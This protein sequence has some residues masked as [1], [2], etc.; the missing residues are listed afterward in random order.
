MPKE[1]YIEKKFHPKTEKIIIQ[2]NEIID[3]YAA[4]GLTLTLRQ[5]YYQFVARG[6]IANK[7]EEYGRLG[8]V[9]NN[10]RLAGLI[11]WN[12]IEDRTRNLKGLSHWENPGE[13][14]RAAA[15][16][17]QIDHWEGQKI[18]PEVWIEKEALVGIIVKVCE[19]LDVPYFAC[20]GYVSQSEMWR[21]SKRFERYR[22]KNRIPIII[23]LGDHDPSGIDMTRDINDRQELF[24]G[25]VT[26][27]RIALNMDQ[28]E[29]YSPPP[30]PAKISDSRFNDYANKFGDESWEFRCIRTKNAARINQ[31]YS[32]N[33]PR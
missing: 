2:V 1:T 22:D 27:K 18:Q 13:I 6:F 31:E 10:G 24:I 23:H 29:K 30:N 11:D 4:D 5:L 7:Q 9:V 32:F 12:A 16:G 14:I 20:R 33:V 15:E 17:F 26:V 25:G 21:A 28:V 8:V 19:K 3:E